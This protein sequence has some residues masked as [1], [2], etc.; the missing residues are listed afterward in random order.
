MKIISLA[1]MKAGQKGKI[2]ELTGG[3]ELQ[4]KLMN[5]GMFPG[6]SVT[7]IGHLALN[8]PVTI[9]CGRTVI[10]LGHGTAHKVKV[11]IE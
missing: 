10:A 6:R 1:R 11:K 8:G 3:F 2:V 4:S 9:R 5:M 7:K